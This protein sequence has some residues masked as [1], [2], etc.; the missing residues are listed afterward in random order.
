MKARGISIFYFQVDNVI[1]NT[2]TLF[3]QHHI[4]NAEMSAR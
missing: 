2:A 4:E 1:I 3:S